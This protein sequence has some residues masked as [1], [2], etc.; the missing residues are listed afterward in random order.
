MKRL[1]MFTLAGLVVISLVGVSSALY[2]L[3]VAPG[4][5]RSTAVNQGSG[6]FENKIACSVVF[7]GNV[8]HGARLNDGEDDLF[9]REVDLS[10]GLDDTYSPSWT[11]TV[12]IG[13]ATYSGHVNDNGT[14]HSDF[15]LDFPIP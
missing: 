12:P 14:G 3:V 6:Y 7:G 5:T 15:S 2:E 4:T 10:F 1:L 13:G 9:F 11:I 8:A